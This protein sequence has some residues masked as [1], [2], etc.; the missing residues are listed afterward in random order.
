MI[1]YKNNKIFTSKYASQTSRLKLYAAVVLLYSLLDRRL[2]HK[3][4][5]VNILMKNKIIGGRVEN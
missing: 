3:Y 1:F 5:I 2:Q 4:K